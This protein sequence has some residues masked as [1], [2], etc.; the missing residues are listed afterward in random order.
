MTRNGWRGPGWRVFNGHPRHVKT[1]RDWIGRVIACHDGPVDPGDAE[2]VVTELFTNALHHGPSGGRVLV[3]Y[4][5]WRDRG[6]IVVC[7]G[8]G[9]TVPRLRDPAASDQGG[10]GLRVVDTIAARWDGFRIG[11]AQ[12]VWC[13]I[14]QPLDGATGDTCAWLAR[15]LA[16]GALAAT[17]THLPPSRPGRRACGSLR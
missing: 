1:V 4:C 3:G 13:D 2:L 7:D 9:A 12:V 6:R 15:L 11:Q 8:G 10:R 14:G 17:G 16:E 5:L